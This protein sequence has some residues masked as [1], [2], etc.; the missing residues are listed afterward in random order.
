MKLTALCPTFLSVLP[1][2]RCAAKYNTPE[3]NPRARPT[4][5]PECCVLP[6]PCDALHINAYLGIYSARM[7]DFDNWKIMNLA[8][9]LAT[10]NSGE[11]ILA[12]SEAH[13]YMHKLSQDAFKVT[14]RINNQYNTPEEMTAL[15]CELTGQKV[16]PTVT[17]FPPVFTDCGKNLHF[18]ENI[19]INSG[20]KFQD[21]G[22]IDIGSGTLV[23]HNVVFASLN[24]EQDPQARGNLLPGKITVGEN[25]WIGANATILAGVTI[26]DGA[27]IAAGAVVTKDVQS[28]TIAG[29]VPAKYIKDVE[30]D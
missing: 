12:G 3:Y 18:A 19:F 10:L 26:G 24:H 28:N 15:L 2:Q 16:S 23:G 5:T 4:L 30:A 13:M 25:V 9:F 14:A 20:C 29:G 11:K 22:G 6:Y 1:T 8:T 21:Q 7:T 17:V 27:I